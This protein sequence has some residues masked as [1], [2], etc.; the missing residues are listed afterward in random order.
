MSL[1]CSCFFHQLTTYRIMSSLL[2]RRL[3]SSSS[4]SCHA[5]VFKSFGHPP[6]VIEKTDI[7]SSVMDK[8]LSG[9]QMLVKFLASPVNP[10]DINTIQ[11][12][13]GIKPPLPAFA[14][15]EGVAEVLA[16]GPDVK[17]T[18]PGDWVV[19]AQAG[20]GTWRT[21][22]L[23]V[24]D[25]LI[26]LPKEGLDVMAA[27]SITVNP[28]TA[29]RMLKDF[30]KLQ[31][32]DTVLQNGANSSVGVH[33]IQIAKNWGLKTVN[34]IRSRPDGQ[35][36]KV[37]NELR[38]LGAD[39]VVTEED[40][41]D[42]EK[43]GR[44]WNTISKPKLALNCVSGKNGTDC[45]R[46]LSFQGVMVTYGAMS[47]QPLSLPAGPLI[48]QDQRFFGFWM[49]RWNQGKDADHPDRQAMFTDLCS[50]YR[51]G[52]L[53]PAKSVC[54]SLENYKEALTKAT[55]TGFNQ[56]KIVFKF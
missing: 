33:V 7:T 26:S 18:K 54:F 15:N 50:M 40:L 10:A 53:Q 32:G 43:M 42:K 25:M 4:S 31:T 13:Y 52:K 12:V 39:H 19:P 56:G 1:L 37:A 41:R 46:H 51:E 21:H 2:T 55:D 14:G 24:E 20:I 38:S 22:A 8:R 28:C 49:T 17:R 5:L 30:V 29:Y 9:N 47:K 48:F 23:A 11:G 6:D 36:E 27:A 16:V 44:I 34:V 45:L 35:H 3:F